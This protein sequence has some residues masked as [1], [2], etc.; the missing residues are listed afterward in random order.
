MSK[1][2]PLLDSYYAPYK[3][4]TRYWTGFLLLSRCALYIVFSLSGTTKSLLAILIAFM[5]VFAIALLTGRIYRS[6]LTNSVETCVYL[7]LVILSGLTLAEENAPIVVNIMLGIVFAVTIAT[8]V[9]R[10]HILYIA[11]SGKWLRVKGK[12]A[13]LLQVLFTSLEKKKPVHIQ[14]DQYTDPHEP[15]STTTVVD[16]REPLLEN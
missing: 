5:A 12:T 7:N 16:L 6:F 14:L 9:Y 1:L 15:V 4:H 3:A 8:I 13:H 11:G 2:K 10:F